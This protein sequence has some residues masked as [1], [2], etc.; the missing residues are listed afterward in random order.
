MRGA[1]DDEPPNEGA[2]SAGHP[3]VLLVRRANALRALE[4]AEAADDPAAAAEARKQVQEA[5]LL[6]DRH[7]LE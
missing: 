2:L 7:G 3:L 6:I 5:Q 4:R 1:D